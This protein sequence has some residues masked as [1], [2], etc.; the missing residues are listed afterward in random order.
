MKIYLMLFPLIAYSIKIIEIKEGSFT[1]TILFPADF[2]KAHK[3]FA[4]LSQGKIMGADYDAFVSCLDDLGI[5]DSEEFEDSFT[6]KYQGDEKSIY[7]EFI[8][9]YTEQYTSFK[10]P[11]YLESAID[12]ELVWHL[13]FQHDY[14]VLKFKENTF[15][16]N[17]NF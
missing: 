16:F 4:D 14:Q 6:G 10:I 13:S 15:F 12:Y 1:M 17:R 5:T 3:E 2:I 7:K 11:E 9:D 8:K